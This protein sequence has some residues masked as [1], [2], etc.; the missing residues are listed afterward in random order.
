MTAAK[1]KPLTDFP[2]AARRDIACVL[3]DIDDTLTINGRITASAFTALEAL[4]RAGIAVVPVTGR[5]AGW[6]DHIARHWPVRGVV[7]ENGAFYFS[8]HRGS[9]RVV[10][11]YWYEAARRIADKTRLNALRDRILQ[12]VPRAGIA[13][14]QAYRECDLAVDW[15]EDVDPLSQSEVER[16]VA[17]AKEVGATVRIASIH[18]NVWFGEFSKLGMSQRF[19]GDVLRMD[20]ETAAERFVF[21]GDSP[22]DET[23]FGYFPHSVGVANVLKFRGR[24]EAEPTYVTP[25]EGGDGFAELARAILE[26]R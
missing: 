22:N 5:A 6:C 3:T 13:S 18:V 16:V 19:A 15:C 17:L 21:S 20:T 1:L 8:Y 4:D 11:R 12:E 23:M 10:R 24:L 2:I 25:S 7:G 26:A 14:D 9:R